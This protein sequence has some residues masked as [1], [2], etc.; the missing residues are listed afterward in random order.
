MRASELVRSLMMAMDKHG[1]D[2]NVVLGVNEVDLEITGV[3]TRLHVAETEYIQDL[4]MEGGCGCDEDWIDASE[5]GDFVEG[6]TVI[7]EKIVIHGE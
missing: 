4:D 6:W 1:G 5:L 2:F 7:D 3:E